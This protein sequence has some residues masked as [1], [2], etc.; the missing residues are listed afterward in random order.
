VASNVRF[1]KQ[2]EPG[3]PSSRKLM[4]QGVADGVQIHLADQSIK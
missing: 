2:R 4:P 3:D 1:L